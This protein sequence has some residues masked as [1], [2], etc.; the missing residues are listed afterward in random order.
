MQERTERE[1]GGC[2]GDNVPC[3]PPPP[4]E[5]GEAHAAGPGKPVRMQQSRSPR[6]CV[7]VT[8]PLPGRGRPLCSPELP[9]SS[10]IRAGSRDA[11]PGPRSREPGRGSGTLPPGPGPPL[12][13]AATWAPR[14]DA[15]ARSQ[16]GEHRGA[17]AVLAATAPQGP[18]RA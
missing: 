5:E 2:P 11:R 7:P 16:S 10:R 13:A 6:G 17:T 9:D 14:R 15:A 18:W 8:Q 3:P 12:P 4:L 1:G